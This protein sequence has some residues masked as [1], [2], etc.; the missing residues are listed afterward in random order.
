MKRKVSKIGP[1]TLMVSL[2]APWVKRYNIN[3][4]DEIDLEE[5][6]NKIIVSAKKEKSIGKVNIS[7]KELGMFD[8]NFISYL[9]Q[10]GYDEIRVEFD[11]VKIFNIIQDKISKLMGFEIVNQTQ[12]SCTIKSISTVLETEFDSILRRTFLILV[13]MANSSY[14]AFEENNYQ[15]LKEISAMEIT[16]DRLT[17]FLK[18]ILNKNGYK[19]EEKLTFI[20]CIIRDLEKVGDIYRDI[21]NEYADKKTKI[22]KE[23]LNLFKETNNLFELFYRLFYKFDK[24]AVVMLHKEKNRLM[25]KANELFEKQQKQELKLIHNIMNL[26]TIVF[27]LYGPYFTMVV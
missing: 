7:S 23:T 21:C 22:S 4:G 2:P 16:I 3:K 5:K 17:D 26:T 27:D 6:G 18:R 25:K 12:N 9:Y 15:K 11:D 8:R 20:Y 19:E 24:K 1:A 14:E 13:E 10:K